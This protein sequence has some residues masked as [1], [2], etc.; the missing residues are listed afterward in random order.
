MLY[1]AGF[2]EILCQQQQPAP[3][4]VFPFPCR[5]QGLCVATQ[6]KP[7]V[8]T[9]VAFFEQ[10]LDKMPMAASSALREMST[11]NGAVFLQ[12]SPAGVIRALVALISAV[13]VPRQALSNAA[14]TLAGISYVR[15]GQK[16]YLAASVPS[17]IVKLMQRALKGLITAEHGFQSQLLQSCTNCLQK[18]SLSHDGMIKVREAGA[19]PVLAQLLEMGDEVRAE[20]LLQLN[21]IDGRFRCLLVNPVA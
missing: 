8:L 20:C 15:A 11:P 9:V 4:L 21:V 13:Y 3:Q 17:H 5:T 2:L 7:F 1:H 16:D 12:Q 10:V 19:I 6:R 14:D 18:L